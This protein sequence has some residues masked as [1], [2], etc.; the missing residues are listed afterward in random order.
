MIINVDDG[1]NFL[2]KKWILFLVLSIYH[3][4]AKYFSTS[5]RISDLFKKYITQLILNSLFQTRCSYEED[6]IKVWFSNLIEFIDS[7][8]E[9]TE[10]VGR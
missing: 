3:G 10:I 7:F 2:I 4:L 1:N 5:T 8:Y 6:V 9:S